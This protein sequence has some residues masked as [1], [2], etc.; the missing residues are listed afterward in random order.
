MLEGMLRNDYDIS[1]HRVEG[2]GGGECGVLVAAQDRGMPVAA[3]CIG[4]T[5]ADDMFELKVEAR[6]GET[7][8]RLAAHPSLQFKW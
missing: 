6:V 3:V 5:R 8:A 4:E 2:R 7:L 1:V